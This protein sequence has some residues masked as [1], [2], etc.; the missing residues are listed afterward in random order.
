MKRV[1]SVSLG[2]SKRDKRVEAEFFGERFVIERI[3]TDGD[4][5]RFAELLQQLDGKV[6]ALCF[7]GM[8]I[9]IR[10]GKRK[11]ALREPMKLARIVK[12]TPVVDGSGLKDTMEREAVHWLQRMGIVNFRNRKVL[13]VSAIDRFGMA[14]ELWNLGADLCVGDLAFGLGIPLLIKSQR[15]YE[16]LGA[17]LLPL[18]VQLPIGWIYPTGKKQEHIK[19]KFERFY[20]WAEVIAG[21]FLLIR[22]HLPIPNSQSPTPLKDKIV[23]TNTTTRE[24]VELLGRLGISLLITTTPELDGRTFGTNVMEGVLVAH[25]RRRPDELSRE[26]YMVALEKL[27][28]QPNVR[29]LN[30]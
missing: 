2:S 18:I 9:W 12:Q 25:L 15:L 24:D 29:K 8:D 7:G 30:D 5:Q 28:W 26:D 27:G 11:Y 21:D 22:K 16:F 23:L 13:L 19:P 10:C 20:R 3:G 4:L 14:E 1:V 6:D 17:I